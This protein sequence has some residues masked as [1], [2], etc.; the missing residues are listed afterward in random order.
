MGYN[1]LINGVYWGYNPLILTIDPFTSFQRDILPQVEV[2]EVVEA[3]AKEVPPQEPQ[4]VIAICI[5]RSGRGETPAGCRWGFQPSE[6]K[7]T[8]G[9]LDSKFVEKVKV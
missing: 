1:L 5:D 3:V 9:F 7:A 4:E 8:M 2:E 6:F